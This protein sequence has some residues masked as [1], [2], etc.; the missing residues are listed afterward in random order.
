MFESDVQGVPQQALTG[1]LPAESR[2]TEVLQE[3]YARS[4]GVGDGLVADYIP[5]LAEADPAVFGL[6][7][8]E[9]D[10]TVHRA[11]DTAAAFTIQSISKA[12]ALALVC[13]AIGHEE[14]HRIVGVNNTGL[15]FNSV[16]ALE[17]NDGSPMNPMVNAGAIAT[18]ALVPGDTAEEQWWTLHE[19]LSRFAGRSL[20]LDTRVLESESASNHRNQGIADLLTS[21]D[22]LHKGPA[23]MVDLYTR[24]CS[25]LVTADD[26]AV[27]GATLADG[28]INP[29]TGERVVS[30]EVCRDTL[31]V[32]A[33]CGMYELSGEWLFE[34]G[35][36][37]KSGVSG[38]IVA[39]A[40]GK[41]ALGAFSPPLDRAGNSVRGQ[42][43]CAHLSRALGLNL[44]ASR[45]HPTKDA[46]HE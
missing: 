16:I 21:Y 35:L 11:G 39:I 46:E 26:L 28:G 4:A 13:E 15:P 44:F 32:L 36:P 27:M 33:A 29:V 14:V 18:T 8:T 31:S 10:G 41:G 25:L 24:Q 7:L 42:R 45:P 3:A 6:A 40:P 1:A 2:V 20:E 38:G 30:P 22:R 43:A 19:G 23:E 5:A 17:L 34:I 37:A 9:V 12:F